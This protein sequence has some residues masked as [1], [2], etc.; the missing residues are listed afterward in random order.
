MVQRYLSHVPIDVLININN[1]NNKD[2]EVITILIINDKPNTSLWIDTTFILCR[3]DSLHRPRYS[4][5]QTKSQLF[6]F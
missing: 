4:V 5:A 1:I 6:T 3:H 2:K